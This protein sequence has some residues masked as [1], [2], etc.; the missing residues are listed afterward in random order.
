MD[1][2]TLTFPHKK[3]KSLLIPVDQ[4]FV[5]S[6]TVLLPEAP[7]TQSPVP[8]LTSIHATPGRGD[9]GDPGYRGNCSGLLIKDLLQFYG[10]CRVLDCME[11]SG[12]C[13]DVCKELGIA[14]EGRD[15]K[16]GFDA[17][18]AAGFA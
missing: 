16:D 5:E 3:S 11:G 17:T 14:Y 18:D 7:K 2:N 4:S 8:W 13:R 12:T 9:Y 6:R 10:A 15:L 1:R